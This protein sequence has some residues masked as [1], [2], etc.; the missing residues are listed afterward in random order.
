MALQTVTINLPDGLYQQVKNRAYQMHRS[1]E[2]ELVAVVMAALP[3]LDEL[4]PDIAEAINQL[5]F[6]NDEELWQAARTTLATSEAERTQALLLKQQQR[7]VTP[8]EEQEIKQLAHHYDQ[9]MLIR[10]KAAVLLK[11]RGYDVSS[12][13]QPMSI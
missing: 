6:L 4:P 7:G 2:D 3:A 12:L 9:T 11:E 13:K 5:A 10:A 8:Q 1:V